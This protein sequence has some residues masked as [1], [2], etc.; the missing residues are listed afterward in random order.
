MTSNA[1]TSS[2]QLLTGKRVLITGVVNT[3][4]IAYAT[5]AAAIE[6]G[7]EI[8]LSS[9]GRASN[10]PATRHRPSAMSM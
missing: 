3:D 9:L 8:V 5:A 1:M 4:S 2:P 6:A 7:A 10:T